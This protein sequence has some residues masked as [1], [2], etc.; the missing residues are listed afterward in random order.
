MEGR[1]ACGNV[2]IRERGNALNY[3]PLLYSQGTVP[4]KSPMCPSF[5]IPAECIV[6]V[7]LYLVLGFIR[8]ALHNFHQ[9][10]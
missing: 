7:R 8:G 9:L 5:M 10:L 3:P 6:R 4:H 2:A 1:L